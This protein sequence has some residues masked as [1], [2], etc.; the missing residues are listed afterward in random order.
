MLF[1]LVRAELGEG[2]RL[3]TRFALI[4]EAYARGVGPYLHSLLKQ[5]DAVDRLNQLS[6]LVKQDK[7]KDI[8]TKVR[9]I[10]LGQILGLYSILDVRCY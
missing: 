2:H 3:H 8:A 7:E 5:V 4:L 9:R 6:L 10:F 1:W